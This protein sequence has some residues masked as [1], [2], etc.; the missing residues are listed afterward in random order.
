MEQFMGY[1]KAELLARR[2]PGPKRIYDPIKIAEE[3]LEWVDDDDSLNFV[4]FCG[5]H[6]YLPGLIWRLDKEST[7]FSE[8]YAIAKMKLAARRE[9]HLNAEIMNYGAYQRYQALY[10][11]FLRRDETDEKDA[12]AKRQKGIKDSE[13]MNLIQL[14]KLAADGKISQKD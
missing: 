6:G 13:Q 7:E 3:L 10:D 11:P 4:Q 2:K 14:A 5:D 9:R 8:A 12:D 1:S